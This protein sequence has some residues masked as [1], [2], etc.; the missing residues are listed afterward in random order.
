M[1][2]ETPEWGWV[3]PFSADWVFGERRKLPMGPVPSSGRKRVLVHYELG[4]N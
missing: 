2:I 3:S 4:D 1:C